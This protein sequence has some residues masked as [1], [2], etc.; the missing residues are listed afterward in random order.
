MRD[1]LF[2]NLHRLTRAL[3]PGHKRTLRPVAPG[4]VVL[5]VQFEQ[6]LGCCVHGT[7]ILHALRAA[8][9]GVVVVAATRG[10]GAAT[11][12]HH[13]GV[14][15]L[16]EIER[17]PI[18]SSGGLW[19]AVLELRR[20][21]AKLGLHPDVVIGDASSRRG[22]SA[23][24]AALLRLA[25]SIGF[26][27]AP[28]LYD[29]PLIYDPSR[30]LIENN[31]R[32]AAALSGQDLHGEPAV[33]FTVA[34]LEHARTLLSE[35]S[36]HRVG[37]VG[38]VVQGSGGQRTGWH[39]NRFAEVVQTLESTGYDTVFLGT[40][41]D[42]G[43]IE[44]IRSLAHARGASLA[45]KTTIPQAAAV[46]CHCDLLIS[47]DT[48][49]MH[50]GRAVGVPMVVLGPSWQPPLEWLPL[51]LANVRILRGPDRTD[52]PANY[53]LDEIR[54]DDV[55]TAATELLEVCPPSAAARDGRT[56]ARLSTTRA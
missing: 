30:S 22:R 20:R 38:L 7:P 44:R 47:V 41:A 4:S 18:G 32:L 17:D 6:P 28:G 54:A 42:G 33:F 34:D 48:G 39:E 40:E 3:R 24:F 1:L 15:H 55:L 5:Y 36:P 56:Q 49:T 50:L 23:L 51:G 25:P 9:P 43:G 19:G 10:T 21:L 52:V 26:G 29:L 14:D 11:L 13:P 27:D 45:G 46:L 31:L 12:R 16:I 35:G 2:R 8:I 53:L 37:L